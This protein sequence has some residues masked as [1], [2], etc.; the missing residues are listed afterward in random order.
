MFGL[1]SY[2]RNNLFDLVGEIFI[3]GKFWRAWLTIIPNAL[4]KNSNDGRA[5]WEERSRDI[6]VIFFKKKKII[7]KIINEYIGEVETKKETYY[8]SS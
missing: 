2:K 6:L 1:E 5:T 8:V 7:K 3:K 4:E